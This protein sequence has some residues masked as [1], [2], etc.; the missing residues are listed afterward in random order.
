MKVGILGLPLA[1][2]STLWCL[3]T[4]TL[5]GPDPSQSGKVQLKTVKIRDERLERLRED[6][7]PRKCTPASIELADFPAVSRDGQDR[8]GV[9]QLLA[10]ARNMEVLIVVIRAFES[11]G[12]EPVDARRD[13][14]EIRSELLLGDLV[15]V[16]K[17]VE[18]LETQVK[19][20]TPTQADDRRELELLQ[21][22]RAHLEA[23]KDLVE[24]PFTGVER[25][26]VQGYQFL[27]SKPRIIVLNRGEQPLDEAIV[28]QLEEAA[29]TRVFDVPGLNELEIEQLPDDDRAEFREA[30]GVEPGTRERIIAECYRAAG[31]IGFFT[32]GEKEVRAW[33]IRRGEP[34]VE[35][36]GEIHSDMARGFIRAETVSYDDYVRFNGVKGAREAGHLRLEGKD[37]TVQDGDIIEFRFS[38]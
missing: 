10:P 29:G 13:W 1:G 12:P 3:L 6:Y 4:E 20:P 35:A 24:F 27:S 33:T 7:G 30:M 19:K 17:R 2:K 16:E 28:R 5:E 22:V 11:G 14:D 26:I 15:I 18:K 9:A 38:V 23:E 34:A 32:V 37:Y 25:R 36:A 31:V 8:A 21:R